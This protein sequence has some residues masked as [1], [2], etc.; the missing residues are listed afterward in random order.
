MI[1]CC[2]SSGSS[3]M[4]YIGFPE[5]SKL[6]QE[7]EY[8]MKDFRLVETKNSNARI[9]FSYYIFRKLSRKRKGP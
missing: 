5:Q 9:S 7:L 1:V 8:A 4:Y 6:V 2:T 3:G